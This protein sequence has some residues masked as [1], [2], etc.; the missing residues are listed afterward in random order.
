MLNQLAGAADQAGIGRPEFVAEPIAAALA[1]WPPADAPTGTHIG[2]IDF[3]ARTCDV[4][5]VRATGN[6][7]T[8]LG[9]P[10]SNPTIGGEL[11]D[12]VVIGMIG[13]FL[14][15]MVWNELQLLADPETNRLRRAI[16]SA[17][18]D[19]SAR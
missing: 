4:T 14:D 6:G 11:L 7:Y 19:R 10:A 18:R 13:E 3:G 2:V 15:P 1:V 17:G 9:R 5:I 8:I 16:G 12:E